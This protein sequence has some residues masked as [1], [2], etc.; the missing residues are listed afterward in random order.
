MHMVRALSAAVEK[1]HGA[2]RTGQI[3]IMR[4]MLKWRPSIATA[5]DPDTN[6]SSMKLA[7]CIG[8]IEAQQELNKYGVKI[9]QT[10]HEMFK[11]FEIIH[12][13][14]YNNLPLFRQWVK[15]N[16]GNLNTRRSNILEMVIRGNENIPEGVEIL[17]RNG[18]DPDCPLASGDSI[19]II[20]QKL[21]S[22]KPTRSL[23]DTISLLRSFFLRRARL[24]TSRQPEDA[25]Q[26][27]SPEQ[28]RPRTALEVLRSGKRSCAQK[29]QQFKKLFTRRNETPNSR[30]APFS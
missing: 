29:L 13:L 8:N 23:E 18:A 4:D 10:P 25:G 1:F 24:R 6:M 19:H 26:H 12:A 3:S 28:Q 15:A 9:P 22:R 5:V 17:L 30:C 20:A 14:R 2:I 21:Y 16:K 27:S 7:V 11:A